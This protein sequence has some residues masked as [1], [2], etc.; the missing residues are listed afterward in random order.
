ME[1]A[2]GVTQGAPPEG[3]T[4]TI[5]DLP[6]FVAVFTRDYEK[7]KDFLA[8][9]IRAYCS[10][11]LAGGDINSTERWNG[12]S[13]L[14]Q[15]SFLGDLEMTKFLLRH[16]ADINQVDNYKQTPLMFAALKVSKSAA[17]LTDMRDMQRW[18]NSY[19][20]EV[21]TFLHRVTPK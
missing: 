2:S 14:M 9:G 10:V 17:L 15:A 1:E 12:T 19:Y 20:P 13:L 6:H 4:E 18:F 11:E 8:T 5:A 7:L 16:K 21:P 3:N